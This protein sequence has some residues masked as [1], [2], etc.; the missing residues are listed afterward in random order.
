MPP[1]LDAETRMTRARAR[2]RVGAEARVRTPGVSAPLSPRSV[3]TRR[4]LRQAGARLFAEYGPAAVGMDRVA[5]AAGMGR[6]VAF[7][8]FGNRDELL[9]DLIG[10]YAIDLQTSVCAA[11]DAT[12][13]EGQTTRLEAMVLA[14]LEHVAA[15]RH[16]HRC[17]V[18]WCRLL[19]QEA[20]TSVTIR[21]EITL[22]TMMAPLLAME[23]ALAGRVEAMA[24]LSALFAALLNDPSFWPTPPE[25][26]E[27]VARAR[28]IAGMMRAAAL[29]EA[30]GAWA[31][32]GTRRGAVILETKRV[33]RQWGDVVR[34]VALGHDVVVTRRGKRVARV[35]GVG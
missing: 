20:R 19:G 11:F 5:Q 25:P 23:P 6:G 21:H 35:V 30:E 4:A 18:S 27:R 12:E 10:T 28:A 22:E 7:L 29:A 2:H 8:H 13:G 34:A 17:L 24:R 3:Q 31:G 15:H 16:E 9:Y 33:R 1:V 32:L 14:W 26:P